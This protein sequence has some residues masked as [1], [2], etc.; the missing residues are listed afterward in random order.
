M[1]R[2]QPDKGRTRWLRVRGAFSLGIILMLAGCSDAP[3]PVAQVEVPPGEALVEGVVVDSAIRPVPGA[4]VVAV[5][6]DAKAT[7]DD[8]GEFALSLPVGAAVLEATHPSFAAARAE[9]DVR[10]AMVG[11]VVLTFQF[12]AE[13]APYSTLVKYDGFVVCSLG[14]SVIFSEECG[15]GVGTPA[16]RVGKQANNA[17][18]YDFQPE[19]PS[20]KTIVLDMAWEPTSDAGREMLLL[21]NTGWTCEPACGG[22]AVG[23]GSMQGPSPQSMRVD[24]A[25]LAPHLEDPATVFTTY[26]LA[27]NDATQVNALLNQPFQLF[28]SLFYR[29][30]AP[31]GY[32][33]LTASP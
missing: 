8:Q 19:S 31:E 2:L 22:D 27:R 18:R 14:I 32:S 24:E 28:V 11:K 7:T 33:F 3:K 26:A 15:E 10:P 4:T 5:G 13:T 23:A 17:I 21:F 12:S 9:V 1:A 29:E 6:T 20:V 25:D 30:P 16:G